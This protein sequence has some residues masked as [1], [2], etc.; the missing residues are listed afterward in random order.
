[1][2]WA[3]DCLMAVPVPINRQMV[4]DVLAKSTAFFKKV[5]KSV[6]LLGIKDLDQI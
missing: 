6:V 1:M 4:V 5:K 2:P 3:A